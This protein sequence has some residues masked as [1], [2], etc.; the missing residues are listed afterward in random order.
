MGLSAH[1]TPEQSL[2]G[3]PELRCN[4]F[5]GRIVELFSGD[6]SGELDFTQFLHMLAV[7]SPRATA[8]AKMVWAFALWDFDG[9]ERWLGG[10]LRVMGWGGSAAV[11]LHQASAAAAAT[12]PVLRSPQLASPSL[13][14]LGCCCP[15]GTG[16]DLIG[17]DDIC[18]GLTLLTNARIA[19]LDGG[20]GWAEATA[21]VWRPDLPPACSCVTACRTRWCTP[22]AMCRTFGPAICAP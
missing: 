15:W 5:G 17:N 13:P 7:F 20:D 8:E 11:Q 22:T 1:F 2:M 4:P 10:M 18:K 21:Q 3:V 9:E 16:D 12:S 19:Y 14:L 6:G